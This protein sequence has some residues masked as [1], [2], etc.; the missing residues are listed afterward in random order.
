MSTA[1]S[2]APRVALITGA[3]RG[4]GAAIA[5]RLADEGYDIALADLN[6]QSTALLEVS[7][8]VQR[9]GRKTCV[10]HA[11]VTKENEVK[12]MVNQCVEELGGLYVVRASDPQSYVYHF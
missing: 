3:A 10:I 4:I 2:P 11:D 6:I 1:S 7:E 5:L 12:N 9:K 8:Q